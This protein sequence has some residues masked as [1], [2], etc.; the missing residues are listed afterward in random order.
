MGVASRSSPGSA[1]FI[2]HLRGCS[3]WRIYIIHLNI[4]S[5]SS[6]APRNI[7][8]LLSWWFSRSLYRR[9]SS[10]LLRCF[11]SWL[12]CPSCRRLPL[13]TDGRRCHLFAAFPPLCAVIILLDR[14]VEA[15]W[16]VSPRVLLR[17]A[18]IPTI[19]FFVC[20]A[21]LR[22]NEQYHGPS[23]QLK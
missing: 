5:T 21:S 4:P 23:I 18:V 17:V 6:R 11:G 10:P 14:K 8:K 16:L 12:G 9:V 19:V 7:F 20:V 3:R 22:P 13:H 1:I 15:S 2:S